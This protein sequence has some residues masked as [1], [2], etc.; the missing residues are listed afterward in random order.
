MSEE[1]KTDETVPT[2]A[3]DTKEENP[4]TPEVKK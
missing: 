1:K 3:T 4:V 2:P